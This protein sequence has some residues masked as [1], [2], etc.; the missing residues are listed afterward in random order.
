MRLLRFVP[1]YETNVVV[2]GKEPLFLLLLAFLVA[3]AL[4]RLYTRLARRYGWGS[5]SVH[6][7]HLHHMVVGIIMLLVS[8]AVAIAV[9]PASPGIE[10][11]AIAFGVGAALTLDEFAL[12]LYFRDVY[13]SEEG[14]SSIDATLMAFVFGALL[15]VGTSPFGIEQEESEL[16]RAIA[17]AVIG[18]DVVLA[19]VTFLKGRLMLGLLSIFLPPVG[20]VA[21]VRLAKP[22]SP[23][24]RWFYKRNEGKLA[25][26]HSRF[27][28]RDRRL[29]QLKDRF[30]DLI[31][32]APSDELKHEPQPQLVGGVLSAPPSEHSTPPSGEPGPPESR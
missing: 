13:W 10:V 1:G 20:L 15:L 23:W 16:P 14:R 8:G 27:D 7:V 3:F 21:A 9:T 28:E 11:L 24:A 29:K 25:R 22:R 18:V 31:G 32:G 17:S 26:S 12:W 4:T 5:G 30:Y 19:L 2:S 6:G